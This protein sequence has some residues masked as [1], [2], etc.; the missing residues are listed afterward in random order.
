MPKEN[1][2]PAKI[3]DPFR[4]AENAIHLQGSLQIKNMARLCMSLSS[5]D[6][7]VVIT[8][9]FGIDEQKIAYIRGH[10]ATQLQL[11]C[12]RCMESFDQQLE[13]D[14]LL[15]ILRSDEEADELP[16][17]YN[18]VIVSEDN[19]LTIQDIIEDELIVSLP[20]VPMHQMNDCNV[21][22]PLSASTQNAEESEKQNPFKVI[23][24]LRHKQSK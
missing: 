11:Q 3:L 14:F 15:G 24:F 19:S 9:D 12:Q 17:S 22:L 20:I 8:M 2:L 6:G 7:E 13:D 18:P 10:Y 21:K 5:N 1:M 4:S 23:E 16:D